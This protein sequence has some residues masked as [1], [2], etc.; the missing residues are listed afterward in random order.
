ME[1]F[2]GFQAQHLVHIISDLKVQSRFGPCIQILG[3]SKVEVPQRTCRSDYA[4]HDYTC[5][6]QLMSLFLSIQIL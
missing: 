3:R 1:A 5:L 4:F 6:Y 2:V